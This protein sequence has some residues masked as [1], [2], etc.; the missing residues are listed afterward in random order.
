MA[1]PR[2]EAACRH[3]RIQILKA[4]RSPVDPPTADGGDELA[5]ESQSRLPKGPAGLVAG[6]H[7][8]VT[9]TLGLRQ[10]GVVLLVRAKDD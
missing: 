9:L 5:E 8:L 6:R 7:E 1:T 3:W 4:F 2:K 10:P